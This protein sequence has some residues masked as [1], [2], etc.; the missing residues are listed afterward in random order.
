[1]KNNGLGGGHTASVFLL[2]PNIVFEFFRNVEKPIPRYI[3]KLV[4]FTTII[5]VLVK[6]T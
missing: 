3:S 4:T 5:E 1:M 2:V 6:S